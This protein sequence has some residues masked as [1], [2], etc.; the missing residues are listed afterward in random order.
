[1]DELKVDLAFSDRNYIE[2]KRKHDVLKQICTSL[3]KKIKTIESENDRLRN[4]NLINHN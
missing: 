3:T 1:M 2:I 4:H